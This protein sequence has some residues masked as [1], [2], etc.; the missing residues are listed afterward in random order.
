MTH[1]G[2]LLTQSSFFFCTHVSPDLQWNQGQ[3][4]V[5]RL[6]KVFDGT[7]GHFIVSGNQTA[8]IP[9]LFS[10]ILGTI[11]HDMHFS[12]RILHTQKFTVQYFVAYCHFG[13]TYSMCVAGCQLHHVVCTSKILASNGRYTRPFNHEH[14]E[15][16]C[17]IA[18]YINLTWSLF[19]RFKLLAVCYAGECYN[20]HGKGWGSRP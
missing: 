9:H 12:W 5:P 3:F 15:G 17:G 10:A 18:L 11:N 14:D 6:T 8:P 4:Q 19:I 1:Q 7:R 20:Y 13:F 2:L 16:K